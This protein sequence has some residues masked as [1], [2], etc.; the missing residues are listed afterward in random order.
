MAYV[1]L[2]PWPGIEPSP[3]EG[4]ASGPNHWTSRE[5]RVLFFFFKK[6]N[7][8]CRG[9][10]SSSLS[11]VGSWQ[12]LIRIIWLRGKK[13]HNSR[14]YL[15]LPERREELSSLRQTSSNQQWGCWG[16]TFIWGVF[17]PRLFP[18]C[19]DVPLAARGCDNRLCWLP[20]TSV[21]GLRSYFSAWQMT[22]DVR[23]HKALSK[24]QQ[25]Q[26]LV[27]CLFGS[28]SDRLIAIL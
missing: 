10:V 27:P 4:K 12:V 20:T 18:Q 28:A 6:S 1:I 14:T 26:I 2:F 11:A 7:I 25:R 3:T 24:T 13:E 21:L 16:R 19:T 5:L 17:P 15:H 23:C 22:R 8:W 9:S